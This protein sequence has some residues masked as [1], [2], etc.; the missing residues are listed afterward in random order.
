MAKLNIG[1]SKT[2]GI[3]VSETDDKTLDSL[4]SFLTDQG[5]EELHRR[6]TPLGMTLVELDADE[7]FPTWDQLRGALREKFPQFE[8][9]YDEGTDDEGDDYYVQEYESLE[10]YD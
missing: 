3:S 1:L 8:L 7:M 9:Q 6:K 10:I 4:V 2:V 5:I